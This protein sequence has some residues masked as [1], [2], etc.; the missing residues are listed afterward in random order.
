MDFT[1]LSWE[2]IYSLLR[3]QEL[4]PDQVGPA[5][6]HLGK[7]FNADRIN[8][9]KDVVARYLKDP[10][11]L[12]RHEAMWYLGAWGCIDEYLPSLVDAMQRDPNADNRAF[13]ARCVGRLLAKRCEKSAVL[14]LMTVL[15]NE[16]EQEEVRTSAYGA[17]LMA[18]RGP[19]ADKLADD[20]QVWKEKGLQDVDWSWIES[21]KREHL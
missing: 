10:D 18:M 21:L 12:I 14:Q 8:R 11:A 2:D 7:P 5:I 13:A 15:Q 1:N 19:S 3:G 6:V 20:F 17:L 4:P 9:A 16:S